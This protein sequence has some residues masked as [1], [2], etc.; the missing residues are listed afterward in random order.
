M[1]LTRKRVSLHEKGRGVLLSLQ[2]IGPFPPEIVKLT[3]LQAL[4]LNS[5][6]LTGR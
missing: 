4:Y 5:N 6:Q 1:I 3:N 2:F